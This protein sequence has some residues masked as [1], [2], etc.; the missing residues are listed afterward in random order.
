MYALDVERFIRAGGVR[1]RVIEEGEGEA[2]LL[3]HGVGAWAENWLP[4]MRPLADA[5]YRAIACDLP[6][7]GQS[8]R[9]RR[10]RY[11]DSDDPYYVRFALDVLDALGIERANLFGHSLGGAIAG[12]AALAA[13]HRVRRLV[14]V[15]AGGL[16]ADLP[17]TLRLSAIPLAHLLAR[18]L[19]D[20]DARAYVRSCFYDPRRVPEWLY[21]DAIRYTRAGAGAEFCRVMNQVATVFGVR[22]S[23]RRAWLRRLGTLRCPTL[24]V[25]GREDAVLPVSHA[26]AARELIPHARVEI[27]PGAGHL[28]MVECP[29]E[30]TRIA[31]A[32][33]KST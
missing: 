19:S 13:P 26:E 25:W 5:G 10:V 14:L 27:V 18:F 9:A 4:V 31:L 17:R 22:E 30:F 28:L 15:S 7:H 33:L 24:V 3:V 6:G 23:L 20:E 16:G 2:F 21:A 1:A 32:F 8:G 11:F 29:Q 12:I